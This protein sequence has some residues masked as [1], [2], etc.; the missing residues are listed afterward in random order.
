MIEGWTRY[1]HSYAIVNL[2]QMLVLHKNGI[3]LYLKEPPPF[4][5]EWLEL[6][7]CS[8]LV[9]TEDE[10]E[11]VQSIPIWK[12]GTPI[13]IVYRISYPFDISA[14]CVP[15]VPVILFYTSE[16]QRIDHDHLTGGSVGK[17]IDKCIDGSIIPVT[18]SNWSA[19]ALIKHNIVPFVVPHGVDV[20]KYKPDPSARAMREEFGIPHDA[21]VF[22]NVGAMTGNKNIQGIVK[23]FYRLARLRDNIW[24]VLKGTG[25]LY[26][27][28]RFL[29]ETIKKLFESQVIEEHTW[30]RIRARFVFVNELL[31]WQEMNRLYN[32]A[33][34][35]VSPYVAEGFNM[36]VLEATACGLVCIVSKGGPTDDFLCKEAT[37]F[38]QT[39]PCKT[40]TDQNILLVD[41]ISLQETMLSVVDDKVLS[42]TAKKAGPAHVANRFTWNHAVEKLCNFVGYIVENRNEVQHNLESVAYRNFT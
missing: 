15:N 30:N 20:H 8:H 7:D 23:A 33:D 38:P 29:E 21:Y 41:D 24:L 25:A 22:L 4:R 32:M 11:I 28:K 16:F 27:S 37:R 42:A 18:P 31:D 36:P 9:L 10:R 12:E 13:D 26:D 1:P 14:P 39:V 3:K 34:C 19:G 40:T 6:D 17:L 35:Y 5:E 2:Q